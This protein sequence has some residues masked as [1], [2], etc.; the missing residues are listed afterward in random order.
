MLA[1][2]GA[3]SG[4][5]GGPANLGRINDTDQQTSPPLQ[6]NDVLQ[7][8]ARTDKAQ[9]RHI[10]IGW[11]DL[12]DDYP[13]DMDPRALARSRWDAEK[14]VKQLYNRAKGGEEFTSLMEQY[15]EDG[16]SAKSGVSYEVFPG[17][18]HVFEFR[19]MGIRLEV[20]EVGKVL[21]TFGWHIMK[22]VE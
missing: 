18:S 11:K 16:G 17:S 2:L 19:R 13:G 20:G 14:L 8:E 4:S 21:T 9:V 15:S 22:R 7:R 12:Q 10:L 3:C 6:S 1:L 5:P